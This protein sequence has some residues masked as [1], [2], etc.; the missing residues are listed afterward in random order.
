ME[1]T[2]GKQEAGVF[3]QLFTQL[4]SNEPKSEKKPS[5]KHKESRWED[6]S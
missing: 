1:Q 3:R 4:M 5:S 6:E 2:T